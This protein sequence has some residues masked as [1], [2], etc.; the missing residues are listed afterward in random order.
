MREIRNNM[1][2][3]DFHMENDLILG[4]YNNSIERDYAL[5]LWDGTSNEAD[6]ACT[7]DGA[8]VSTITHDSLM[9]ASA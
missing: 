9:R 6:G 8:R 3:N 5:T 7:G 4:I 2:T 1:H